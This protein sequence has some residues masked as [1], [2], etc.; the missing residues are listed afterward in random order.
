VTTIRLLWLS[1]LL[2]FALAAE[3]P[4]PLAMAYYYTWYGTPWGKTG[5]FQKWSDAK[6]PGQLAPNGTDANTILFPPAIRQ[7]K[8]GAYPLIGPY[9]SMNPDVV[10]WHIRL[11][12]A[13]GID[14]F[15]VDWWGD[16]GWQTPKHWT[17]DVFRDVVLPIAEE[18]GFK[19]VLFDESPQF[20][21]NFEQVKQW[22]R[23]ALA[24]YG[25]SPAYL[26]IDG[27]PV[28]AVYQLW[29]GK[30]SPDQARELIR[31]TEDAVGPVYWIFDKM[32]ARGKAGG[33]IDLFCP[34][35]WLAIKEI[36]CISGYAMFSTWKVDTYEKLKPLYARF[37]AS[38]HAAD[39]QIMLPVH[40]GHDNR[41]LSDKPYHMER[42]N[43]ET[44]QG[45]WNAAVEAKADFIGITSFNEWPETT[46]LEPALTWPDP[47]LYLRL[48]A[49][50]QKVT[51]ETPTLPPTGA[52]DPLM[53]DF[54]KHQLPPQIEANR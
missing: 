53:A 37:A 16:A 12:K 13:A 48:T 11:A 27:K 6:H 9:D 30:L 49:R 46:I 25:K 3:P 21:N 36:D 24:T 5:S 1:M 23:E 38:V 40:P 31:E 4:R 43:G 52:L 20:V 22:T 33:G 32:R 44:Y 50:F 29:E 8:S 7:L 14:A 18:E 41:R 34:D 15:L 42:R 54:L 2:P 26:K 19:V 39:K 47:Y 45:F 51:F 35:E 17:R 10:R 28:W